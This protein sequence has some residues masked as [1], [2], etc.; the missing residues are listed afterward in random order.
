MRPGAASTYIYYLII[1]K[2]IVLHFYFR[3]LS[4]QSLSKICDLQNKNLVV[5]TQKT[6]MSISKMLIGTYDTIRLK[7][8]LHPT[9]IFSNCGIC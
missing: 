9:I 7:N 5:P 4:Y 1:N 2:Y 3:K 6:M 8:L